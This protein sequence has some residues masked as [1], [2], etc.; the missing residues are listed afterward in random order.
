MGHLKLDYL[1]NKMKAY[2]ENTF[3]KPFKIT[4]I[5]IMAKPMTEST[6]L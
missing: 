1:Y 6:F 3:V 5:N 4:V 2:Y